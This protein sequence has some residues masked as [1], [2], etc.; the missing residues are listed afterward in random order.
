MKNASQIHLS[1]NWRK[2]SMK[3]N[4]IIL[5]IFALV[6]VG[7]KTNK[8]ETGFADVN[9][10]KL[11]YEIA[12][13]GEP[14]V[15]IHGWSFD[16]RCWD[17]QFSEFARKYRVLRYDLRGFGK[18]SLPD[19]GE[20]YSHTDDLVALMDYLGIE[21]AHILGHSFGGSIAIDFALRYPKRIFS[22]ILPDAAM[23]ITDY[24]Y[25][26]EINDWIGNTWKAGRDSGINKA[27]E[28]WIKGAPFA[29]A[30]QNPNSSTKL[31]NMIAD[32][33]AWH[34]END[35]PYK[36]ITPYPRERLSNIQVPTLIIVGELNP[37]DYHNI[38]DIQKKYIP[39]SKKVVLTGAGHL[40]NIE[41]PEEFNKIVLDFLAEIKKTK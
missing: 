13:L 15:L 3:K 25:S 1:L 34:W 32:Y 39:N 36:G 11:Y 14:I 23:N 16:T 35:D 24:N 8:T 40:L 10:T 21:K 29:P 26:E 33:S 31:R 2:L 4:K 30:M 12:G 41:K 37:P 28:I 22:L 17:D 19:T 18:S 6:L 20:S 9:G 7:C 5:Y 27:K 38:T